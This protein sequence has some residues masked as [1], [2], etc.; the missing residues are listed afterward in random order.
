MVPHLRGS[1]HVSCGL[2]RC[3]W[4]FA[5]RARAS[6]TWPNW[7][8]HVDVIKE[9]IQRVRRVEPGTDLQQRFVMA[10]GEQGRHQRITLLSAFPLPHFVSPALLV[11][12][13]VN[14]GGATKKG[15]VRKKACSSGR[16]ASA[17][18]MFCRD[19]WAHPWPHAPPARGLRHLP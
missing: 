14:A 11:I 3:T 15:H 12:K 8:R 17:D 19:M 13:D 5:C 7:L 6:R 9:G 2:P 10:Q 1:T 16:S 4:M 18:S